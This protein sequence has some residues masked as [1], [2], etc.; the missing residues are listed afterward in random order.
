MLRS[1]TMGSYRVVAELAGFTSTSGEIRLASS[2]PEP[3]LHGPLKWDVW[4]SMS[5][6]FWV[7][8]RPPR[9][10]MRSFTYGSRLRT[11]P[12]GCQFVLSVPATCCGEYSVQVLGRRAR[13]WQNESWA[14]QIFMSA[15][16]ARLEAGQS[17]R[18]ALARWA[19]D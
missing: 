15:R 17:T 4:L 9:R 18:T 12:Y 11:I 8:A 3:S 10:S 14:R 5:A 16:D 1:L 19:R 13:P 7:R 2:I 6:S